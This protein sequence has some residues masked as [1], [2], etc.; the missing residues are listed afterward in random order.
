MANLKEKSLSLQSLKLYI[1]SF[2][3]LIKTSVRSIGVPNLENTEPKKF[4]AATKTII[5][6]EISKVLTKASL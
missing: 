3:D 2:L 1:Y 6:A 4:D 5:S